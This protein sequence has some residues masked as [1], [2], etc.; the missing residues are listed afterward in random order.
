LALLG[1]LICPAVAR[2]DDDALR[3]KVRERVAQLRLQALIDTVGADPDTARRVQ[4]AWH[5]AQ[6]KIRPL[7]KQVQAALRELAPASAEPSPDD[8]K[9]RDL[10]DRVI[11][12]RHQIRDVEDA[13]QQEVRRILSPAQF[14][15]LLTA[16]PEAERKIR[17]RL[18]QAAEE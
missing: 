18:R 14:A 4:G 15:R 11:S 8:A 9:L 7:R 5:G 6:A 2:A 17:E 13:R 1:L 3:G 16:W 12:L 10:S